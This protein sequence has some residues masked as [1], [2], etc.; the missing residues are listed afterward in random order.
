MTRFRLRHLVAISLGFLL[1]DGARASQAA[2]MGTLLDCYWTLARD[3]LYDAEAA[4]RHFTD[5]AHESL[6]TRAQSAN[7]LD[8]LAEILN[9][10]LQRLGMSHLYLLTPSEL[11]YYIYGG[12]YAPHNIDTLAIA[13]IGVQCT[14]EL[15]GWRV[16]SVLEGYPAERA[17]LRRGDLL[18]AA[19]GRPFHPIRSF[20]GGERSVLSGRRNQRAFLIALDPVVESI[21]RSFEKA[22]RNSVRDTVIH[23]RRI[24]YVHL[25]VCAYSPN[26]SA[27][28]RIITESL[29]HCEGIVLD[30]RDGFGGGWFEYLDPFLPDRSGYAT[31]TARARAGPLGP[32]KPDS[33]PPH[34]SYAGRVVAIINEG[35]RSGKEGLADQLGRSRAL[36]V[37]TT[38][39]GAFLGG[40]PFR[41]PGE[42]GILVVPGNGLTMDGRSIEG[43]G[44]APHVAVE[45]PIEPSPPN[46][47]QKERAFAEM[48]DWLEGRRRRR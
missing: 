25:W 13:H 19:D 4:R 24:G 41:C 14:R 17:G 11:A 47:P 9:P 2:G 45:Y 36:L 20:R 15:T 7:D 38:T 21:P 32:M 12:F 3:S 18:V 42:R 46:D 16:R 26:L 5:A 44:V 23:G 10:F 8:E 37:G 22:M 48:L 1:G 28:T 34:S 40:K 31:I 43:N 33:I 6:W 27:F 39:M 35:S 29:G 30:L